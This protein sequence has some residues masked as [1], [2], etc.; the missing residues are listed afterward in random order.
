MKEKA[1]ASNVNRDSILL[2]S[3]IGLSL[4]EF[5]SISIEAM[6]AVAEKIGL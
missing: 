2:C 4:D 6:K 1:F 3:K 5:V